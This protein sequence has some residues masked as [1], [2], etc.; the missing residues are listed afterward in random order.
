MLGWCTAECIDTHHCMWIR[1]TLLL[2]RSRGPQ[3]PFC[4]S[5]RATGPPLMVSSPPPCLPFRCSMLPC[6][7]LPCQAA[8]LMYVAARSLPVP[9]FK[10]CSGAAMGGERSQ[11]AA[12]VRSAPPCSHAPHCACR[13]L[14]CR[15]GAEQPGVV[16]AGQ[17]E[18]RR[19]DAEEARAALR[20]QPVQRGRQ[21]QNVVGNSV[22]IAL[23]LMSVCR[24]LI[25][26][27]AAIKHSGTLQLGLPVAPARLRPAGCEA[28]CASLQ[29]T[30]AAGGYN[31]DCPGRLHG[32]A[33]M[34]PV[35]P[36]CTVLRSLSLQR[37][38][39]PAAAVCPHTLLPAVLCCAKLSFPALPCCMHR[40]PTTW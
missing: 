18:R 4:S 35:S 2:P 16:L 30:C 40:L 38:C 32:G 19:Q 24:W 34:F 20:G 8:L 37:M 10:L 6:Q 39:A 26:W 25:C 3:A 14:C 7:V 31:T 22:V 29:T 5:L 1:C 28:A 36:R 11:L 12:P 27:A 9:S 23:E 17:R 21:V 33:V 15:R 13:H